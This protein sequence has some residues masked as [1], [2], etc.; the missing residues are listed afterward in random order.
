[1]EPITDDDDDVSCSQVK[2]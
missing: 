2:Y 1:M